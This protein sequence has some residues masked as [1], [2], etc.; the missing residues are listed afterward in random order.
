M[1]HSNQG[2]LKLCILLNSIQLAF[3]IYLDLISLDL[4][5]ILDLTY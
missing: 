4:S 3:H 2:T 1:S 5:I